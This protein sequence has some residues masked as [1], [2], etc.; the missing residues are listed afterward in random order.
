MNT[1]SYKNT[2]KLI[3]TSEKVWQKDILGHTNSLPEQSPELAA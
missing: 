2:E 3:N 1:A